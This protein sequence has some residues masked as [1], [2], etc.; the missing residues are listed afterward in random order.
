[1]H[2]LSQREV[3]M[4]RPIQHEID[5]AARR[6]FE[7]SLPATWAARPQPDDYGIDYDV[8]IFEEHE[9]TGVIFKVQ[10]KGT[11]APSLSVDGRRAAVSLKLRTVQ[12]LY[13]QISAP[14]V[15]VLADVTNRQTMWYGPQ[16]DQRL[17]E[18]LRSAV[19]SSQKTIR[20]HIP[21]S[22]VLPNTTDLLLAAIAQCETVLATRTVVQTEVPTFVHHVLGPLESAE[23]I[24]ALQD[25]A[26]A[27]RIDEIEGL[28]RSH[29]LAHA[30]ETVR[31]ILG[32]PQST[33]EAR[34]AALMYTERIAAAEQVP[35]AAGEQEFLSVQ[36]N[37]GLAMKYLARKGPR[38]LKY[39]AAVAFKAAQLASATRRDYSLF[40]NW[41]VNQDQ[42]DP[43]WL[44]TLSGARRK[45]AALVVLRYKQAH[46][47]LDCLVQAD[48]YSVFPDA[49]A[50]VLLAMIRFQLRL[51]QEGLNVAAAAHRASLLMIA[52]FG[53]RVAAVAQQ[54]HHATY[55][56]T[57]A[58]WF[59]NPDDASDLQEMLAWARARASTIE[60]DHARGDIL[61]RIDEEGKEILQSRSIGSRELQAELE[62]DIYHRMA[63][64]V[65]VDLGDR[66]DPIAAII[67]QGLEDLNPERVLRN[68]QHLFV[69][70]ESTG[71]PGQWLRLPTA[72]AKRL[73]CTL[74]GDCMVGIVL[75][76]LYGV[77][78]G[79]HCRDC[80]DVAPHPERWEWSRKWQLEQDK[81]HS[82]LAQ[83][84]F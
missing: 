37:T 14:V 72:G 61:R 80:P 71:S 65:G 82:D 41:R 33:V 43:Y 2:T 62:R 76:S 44:A 46:R 28:V 54:W 75:D 15:V 84:R 38:H 22:N 67:R 20:L 66:D 11:R 68:C 60:P 73:C 32:N 6:Q 30:K 25:R 9:T 17:N 13:H 7:Q 64:A 34:F 50:H 35:T 55:M 83:G 52:D 29:E 24:Q 69:T 12:Y 70:I 23:I 27:L 36:F 3:I 74:H 19:A 78:Q 16:L 58:L 53:F 63:D 39:Y 42:G 5:T 57:V 56:C 49:A 51:W 40:L 18:R 26:D 47:L 59:A 4:R 31:T 10:L 79:A 48:L 81:K 8:E 21:T 77:F 45:A 1:V